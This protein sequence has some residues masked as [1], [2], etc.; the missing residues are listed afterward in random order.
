[1][2][3]LTEGAVDAAAPALCACPLL[4]AAAGGTGALSLCCCCGC[5]CCRLAMISAAAALSSSTV[6]AC[7]AHSTPQH[8]DNDFAVA[9]LLCL[10]LP[11]TSCPHLLRG[12][13]KRLNK[14]A[15]KMLNSNQLMWLAHP[16]VAGGWSRPC[17]HEGREL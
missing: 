7:T 6:R 8:T 9:V 11:R 14:G 17:C 10:P 5:C 12:A 1:M 4:L 2:S 16:A 3:G 13:N 15:N